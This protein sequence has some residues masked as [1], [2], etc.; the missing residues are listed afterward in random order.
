MKQ[1]YDQ[2]GDRD[3][4]TDKLEGLSIDLIDLLQKM[5]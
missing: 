3:V 5:L 2:F 1:T 4:I